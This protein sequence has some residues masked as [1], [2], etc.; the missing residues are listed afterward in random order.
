MAE[1]T[2]NEGQN[3]YD[4]IVSGAYFFDLIFTGL[5]QMPELGKEI[6]GTGFDV[7]PGGTFNTVIALH[8]LGI[9]VG[10]HTEFGSDF[11]SGYIMQ[12]ARD[13]GLDDALFQVHDH[14]W[15]NI[16]ASLSFAEDRA[17]VTYTDSYQPRQLPDLA[18]HLTRC[19]LLPVLYLNDDLIPAS[20]QARA[21]GGMVYMDCAETDISIQDPA[22][23]RALAAV[24]V[25]APNAKEA[26]QF[27][28]AATI[29]E[30]LDQIA[31]LVSTVVIKLGPEGAIA[32]QGSETV[33]V[34]ALPVQVVDTTGA[35]DCFNA[36]F[37]LGHLRGEPLERCLY[38]GNIVG[39]LST[40]ARG[41]RGVPTAADVDRILESGFQ[42]PQAGG[43]NA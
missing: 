22:V 36:G 9:R 8:R 11:F 27:T 15:V 18:Q 34:P 10:W 40:M 6:F 42:P 7:L 38:L 21:R 25:F 4:V 13:T 2:P 37:V 12:M 23:R 14:P 32:R 30:A 5:P 17:F 20:Q 19:L 24:D 3:V 43:S 35:G 1:Q 39:G 26:L 31:A 33:R 29:E 16:S 41:T 28:G